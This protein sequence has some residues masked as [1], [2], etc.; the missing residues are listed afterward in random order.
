MTKRQYHIQL[1]E[2]NFPE[3]FR[4]SAREVVSRCGIH[5]G[6]LDRFV[7]LGLVDTVGRDRRSG[8]W[9]FSMEAVPRIRKIMRLRRDLGINY[10]GIAVVLELLRRIEDLES[11]LR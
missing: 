8:E 6:L 11:R 10:P 4:I 2:A 7:R 3:S 9:F 1:F 5:P